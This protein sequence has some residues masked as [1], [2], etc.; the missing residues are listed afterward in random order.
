MIKKI[1]GI[2]VKEIAY[3]DTSKIIEVLTAGGMY[4]IVAR[5]AKKVNSSLFLG[6]SFLSYSGKLDIIIDSSS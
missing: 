4:S 3:R 6:T 5:G 2:V 1:K